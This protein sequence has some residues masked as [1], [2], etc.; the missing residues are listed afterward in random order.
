MNH[1]KETSLRLSVQLNEKEGWSNEKYFSN[2]V[3]SPLVYYQIINHKNQKSQVN[4]I[5]KLSTMVGFASIT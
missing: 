5:Q 3:L 4:W 1:I 2:T